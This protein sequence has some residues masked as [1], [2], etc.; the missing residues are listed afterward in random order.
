NR[1]PDERLTAGPKCGKC[2]KPLFTGLPQQL[3]AGNAS[4]VLRNNNIPVLVDCWAEWCG[5][6][7]SFAPVFNQAAAE[8]EPW[9][10]LAKLNT[11]EAP[12]LAGQWNIRSIPTLILFRDGQEVQRVSGALPL[13]QLFAWLQQAGVRV[14]GH[15]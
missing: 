9:V 14:P 3:T 8:L 7:K 10:R 11:E 5:P 6:C 1:V 13:E 2:K 15:A 12:Q 4:T